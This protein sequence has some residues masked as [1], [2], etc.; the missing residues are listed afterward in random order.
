[1][2]IPDATIRFARPDENAE[3]YGGEGQPR[4]ETYWLKPGAWTTTVAAS[5]FEPS[6]EVLEVDAGLVCTATWRL[7][8]ANAPCAS[9]GMWGALL[10]RVSDPQGWPLPGA[11]VETEGASAVS[12]RFGIARLGP[13]EPGPYRVRASL[14]G[15][16]RGNVKA[17]VVSGR[18]TVVLATLRLQDSMW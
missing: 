15:F 5:V 7:H 8:V 2:A 14:S 4:L 11:T 13:L 12:S 9:C 1:M 10:V 16:G 3:E 6:T 17:D 18:E